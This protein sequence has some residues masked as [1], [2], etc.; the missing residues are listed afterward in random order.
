MKV[1]ATYVTRFIRSASFISMIGT[2]LRIGG[3]I[4]TLPLALRVIPSEQMGLYYTFLAITGIAFLLD[5]GFAPAIGRNAAYAVGGARKFETKG[6]PQLSEDAGAN[7]ELLG[8]LKHAAQRWYW[9][10]AAILAIL[11]FTAG[12]WFIAGKLQESALPEN[13]IFCWVLFALTTT[14]NLATLYWNNLLVGIGSVRKSARISLISQCVQLAITIAGLL[15]GYGI[16]TYAVVGIVGTVISWMLTKKAFYEDATVPAITPRPEEMSAVFA[17]LWP[18]AWR[19]GVVMIGAF[20][21]Q[22]GNTIVCS[23]RLGLDET[24]T[25]GLSLML[26]SMLLQ[27]TGIPLA[28]KWPLIGQLRVQRDILRIRRI[29][30]PYLYGGLAVALIGILIG[31]FALRP[32]L[33]YMGAK[34]TILP[35]GLFILFGIIYLLEQQHS[36][37][38]MLVL[39]ENRNP[40]IIPAIT[41]GIVIL[42]TSWWAAGIWGIIGLILSQGIIQLLWNNWW[43]IWVAMAGIRKTAEIPHSGVQIES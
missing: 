34:T 21:I 2:F 35:N 31:P 17:C 15:L 12:S 5:F 38:A 39:S 3:G 6:L 1:D 19:Q 25:Y 42:I 37:Y 32:I 30:F 16:W 28:L 11:L 36:S 27:I 26:L 40:F 4:I 41:S 8:Q 13:L 10:V 20:L 18:M 33:D 23:S 7:W 24:A 22:K 14:Y 9:A 43:T 29:F